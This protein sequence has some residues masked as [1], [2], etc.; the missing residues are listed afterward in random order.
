MAGKHLAGYGGAASTMRRGGRPTMAAARAS[1]DAVEGGGASDD[2]G[3]PAPGQARATAEMAG[4][5]GT[6]S[7]RWRPAVCAGTHSSRGDGGRT[8][9]PT[10]V[11]LDELCACDGTP[12]ER[13]AVA[14]RSDLTKRA[15]GGPRI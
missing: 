3:P 7:Q 13:C 8:L 10:A 5:Q 9:G 2:G 11:A 6:R 14:M 15:Q 4:R 12:R 1:H